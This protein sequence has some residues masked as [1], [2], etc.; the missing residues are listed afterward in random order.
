M[1]LMVCTNMQATWHLGYW[2]N[3]MDHLCF[4]GWHLALSL[5]LGV[6][7]LLIFGVGIPSLFAYMVWRHRSALDDM[8]IRDKLGFAYRSYK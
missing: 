8:R 6:P 1:Q 4:R 2:T 3:D 5:G 7:S